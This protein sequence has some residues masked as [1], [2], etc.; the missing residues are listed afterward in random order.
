MAT[1]IKFPTAEMVR[2]RLQYKP[3]T[4]E[5]IWIKRHQGIK[6]HAPAG[7]L[8]PDGRREICIYGRRHKAARLAWL[9]THGVWPTGCIDHISGDPSDDRIENLRDV[10][11][12]ENLQ[13]QVRPQRSNKSSGYLGVTLRCTG[14]WQARIGLKGKGNLY[15]GSYETAEAAHQAYLEAKRKL[16]QGCTI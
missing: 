7:T 10:S 13:N 2:E 11:H 16:H 15:L 8:H 5:F 9:L 1:L 3:E 4:G 6:L 12:R 14:K